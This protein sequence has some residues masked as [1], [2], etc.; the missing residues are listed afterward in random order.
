MESHSP[1]LYNHL[2]ST[3]S[4]LNASIKLC[5]IWKA[6]NVESYP[7][8]VTKTATTSNALTTRACSSGKLKESGKTVLTQSTL[9]NDAIK[10]W[11][12]APKEIHESLSYNIA[13]KNI[14]MF[15]K[16]LPV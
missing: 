3:M 14:K 1:F 10:A 5:D 12:L 4:Q 15:A 11:N 2:V 16:T 13:K 9:I 8:K 7:T 6:V